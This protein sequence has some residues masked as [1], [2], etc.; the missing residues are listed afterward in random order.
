VLSTKWL[1]H[2]QYKK[3]IINNAYSPE[4]FMFIQTISEAEAEGKLREIYEGDQKSLGYV[5][6]YAKV[7]SLRSEVLEAWRAFQ[8]SIRKNLRLRRYELVTIAAARALNCRYCL[9]AHGAVLIKNG[10]SIDQLRTIL[11]N[12]H[13]AGLERTEVAI[14]EFAQKI[15]R[16]AHEMTQA[17][18]DTLRA[19]GLEDIE[20][21]DITLTATM[22]NFASKTFDA[23]GAGPDEAYGELE[24]QLSD[25]LPL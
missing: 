12:F 23:L 10:V 2:A 1:V 5:P 18:V 14:M 16:S 22:R 19:L 7:F 9:L 3:G 6:N 21:L 15:T 17:D 13:Q 8:G 25:L 11:T 20:I 24:K 4:E